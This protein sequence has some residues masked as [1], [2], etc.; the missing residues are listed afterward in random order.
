MQ[1]LGKHP[2]QGKQM[3]AAGSAIRSVT[4]LLSLTL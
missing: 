1:G 4:E 3:Q 2:R